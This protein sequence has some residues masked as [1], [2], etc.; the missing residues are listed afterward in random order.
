MDR[1][2]LQSPLNPF[3]SSQIDF[4][5]LVVYSS[6]CSFVRKIDLNSISMDPI[7]NLG[8]G[9][10]YQRLCT[11]GCNFSCFRLIDR[12]EPIELRILIINYTLLLHLFPKNFHIENVKGA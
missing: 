8:T 11:N 6:C 10:V 4:T 3:Q 2:V 7:E 12:F 5:H 9:T 1:L